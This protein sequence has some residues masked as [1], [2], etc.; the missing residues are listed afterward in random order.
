MNDNDAVELLAEFGSNFTQ[1]DTSDH[2]LH[3]QDGDGLVV[4]LVPDA[5][6]R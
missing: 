6:P 5:H 4:V 3:V 2:A 1:K